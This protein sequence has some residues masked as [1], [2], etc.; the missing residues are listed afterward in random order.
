M[1]ELLVL[2]QARMVLTTAVNVSATPRERD[3]S[4]NTKQDFA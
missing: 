1:Q 4:G 3:C 2:K